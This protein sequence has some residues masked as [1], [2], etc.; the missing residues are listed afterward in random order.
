MEDFLSVA[1]RRLI[2]DRVTEHPGAHLREVARRA[3]LPLGTTLYHL[4]TLESAGFVVA[5]RDGRYKRYFAPSGDLGRREKEVVSALRHGTPRRIV[6]LL[7]ACEPGLTQRELCARLGASRSTLSFH[8]TALVALGVLE[9]VETRPEGTYRLVERDLVAT[10]FA[11]YGA[12]LQGE[13]VLPT[14]GPSPAPAPAE[15]PA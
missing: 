10:L 1:S 15:V 7:L 4:D 2:L 13:Q 9:R 5:R 3:S 6:E 8:T 11:R 12:S 14:P